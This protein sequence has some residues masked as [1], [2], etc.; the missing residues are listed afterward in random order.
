MP[1]NNAPE[2]T[3]AQLGK[4]FTWIAWLLVLGLLVIFFQDQ[5][6]QGWN[7]N[8]EPHTAFSSTGKAEV[9]LQQN[10]HG[11]YLFNGE[12]NN[13]NVTFL[14][15]TGATAVSIPLHIAKNLNLPNQGN[16]RVN[17]ANGVVTVYKT[18]I[19]QL[20]LGNIF[21][22]QVPANI[23]LCMKSDEILLGMSALKRVEFSQ[24]GKHLILREQ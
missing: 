13:H 8:Q 5:L 4:Y 19:E 6:D 15:D 23:N 3:S 2:D 1:Q 12:I 16:Y 17:T 10:R 18:V 7:P 22:Y 9:T 14:L 24:K 20:K 21:L 11:H